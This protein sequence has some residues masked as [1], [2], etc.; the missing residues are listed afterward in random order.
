M[1]VENALQGRVSGVQISNQSGQ[2]GDAPTI[3]IRGV[4]TNGNPNPIYIVDGIQVD[5]ID[6]LNPDDIKSIDILKDAASTAIYGARGANGVVLITT[7][8]GAKG[9]SAEYKTY[10]GIQNPWRIMDVMNATEYANFI[11]KGAENAGRK[12]LYEN[13]DE[14][15]EGTDWQR[16]LYNFNAPILS[17]SAAFSN[18]NEKTSYNMA[19]SYFSQEGIVGGDKS[20]YERY[21]ARLNLKHDINDKF[22][23]GQN[24]SYALINRSAI[25]SNQEFGGLISNAINLD[26]IS[27]LYMEDEAVLSDSLSEYTLNPAVKNADGK[28]YGISEIVAQE[29]VNPLARLEVTHGGSREAKFV[30]NAYAE[31]EIIKGLKFKSL[32]G[33]ELS[34]VT[35]DGYAPSYYLNSA[36]GNV[37]PIV[38]KYFGKTTIWNS[39]NTLTYTKKMGRSN[40]N[41]M[42]GGTIRET[43]FEWMSGSKTG[44]I[45]D[46]P[47]K[48]NLGLA[49]DNLS[50][51]LFGGIVE[52]A[53]VSNFGRV[54]YDFDEKYIVS[55]IVRRDGSTKF[56]PDN[57]FGVFPS[58]SAGWVLSKENFF[59]KDGAIS[60]LKLRASWG[61]NGSDQISDYAWVASIYSGHNYTMRDENGNEILVVGSAPSQVADPSLSWEA[62]EQLDFGIDITFW[63]DK[64]T[65]NGDWFRKE[66][67]GL[68]I[69]KPVPGVAGNIAGESNVGGVL[70]TGLEAAL[71]YRNDFGKVFLQ[72]GANATYIK[73]EVLTVDG[74]QGVLT[75]ASISTYG[76]VTRMEAGYRIAYFYGYKTDGIFQNQ[77]EVYQHINADGN[78]LQPKAVPGDVK[79]VDVNGDGVI[80]DADRTMIGSPHPKLIYG[81]NGSAE[82]GNWK[83]TFLF[84]G[85]YGNDVFNG[86]RRHDL[87]ETNFPSYFGESWDGEGSS[88]TMPRFTFV[89]ANQNYSRISDIYVESGSFL[90]LRNL[91]IGYTFKPAKHIASAHV[92]AAAENLLTFTNYRGLEPEIGARNGWVLDMGIDRGVYP[93]AKTFR[94]GIDVKF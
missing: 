64:F 59:P 21:T 62:S 39:E 28:Y 73:N 84:F 35:S 4:G 69:R 74:A 3:T 42:V 56:G 31:Y 17:H 45:T 71:N 82:Y 60:F 80:N 50:A 65:F 85:N 67:K 8:T 13:P 51:Q 16:A 20:R 23:V 5:A 32:V 27:P 25:A 10:Y 1:R 43:T 7:S 36:Q 52:N 34:N 18:S 57:R 94:V 61:Q 63:D 46:D 53:L 77:A 22:K 38:N 68:L 81:F 30:G 86:I 75:G 33:L 41:A 37:V 79:Y 15:G 66:T 12:P 90:R 93:Q 11:N 29:I 26:P 47:D 83:A 19:L 88:N 72:L 91:T 92:Y 87:T 24:F 49:V 40:I 6:Y 58:F 54:I 89:D 2:P 44:L 48:V 78:P 55:A 9:P 70:N 14:F 76:T